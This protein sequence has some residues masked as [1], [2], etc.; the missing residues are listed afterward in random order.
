MRWLLRTCQDQCQ[1]DQ[2][3]D[4]CPVAAGTGSRPD[5]FVVSPQAAAAGCGYP[6]RHGDGRHRAGRYRGDQNVDG[7]TLSHL[8][9]NTCLISNGLATMG[10]SLPGA[11]AAK[12][13]CPERKVLAVMGD[14]GF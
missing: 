13:A 7:A 1:S 3:E 9:A 8:E 10:F 6:R 4:S 12:L 5:G 2:C 11:I 14:G